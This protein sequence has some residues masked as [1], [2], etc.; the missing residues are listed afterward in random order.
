MAITLTGPERVLLFEILGIPSTK[1]IQTFDTF[2]GTGRQAIT[3]SI[4]N[5][6]TEIDRLLTLGDTDQETRLKALIAEYLLVATD[7]TTIEEGGATVGPGT[8][9]SSGKKRDRIRELVLNI[10]PAFRAQLW[11]RRAVGGDLELEM[12]GGGGAIVRG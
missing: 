10:V 11:Q 1:E 12:G 6:V 2:L 7:V 3:V 5:A 8:R 4:V 9:Y